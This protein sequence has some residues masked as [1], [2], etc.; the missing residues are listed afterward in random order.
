LLVLAN[1]TSLIVG[2][3][4]NDPDEQYTLASPVTGRDGVALHVL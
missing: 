2:H 1:V 4:R 3:P